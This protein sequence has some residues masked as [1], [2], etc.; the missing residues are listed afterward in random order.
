MSSLRF[1]VDHVLASNPTWKSKRI[2]L[3]TN[4]GAT[5]SQGVLSRVAL[6]HNQFN[7][8][9]L[10][11]PEHGIKAI[12]P[13]GEKVAD[14]IDTPTSLPIVSLYNDT[15]GVSSEAL[16]DID[17]VMMDL[18]DVGVRCYTYLWSG[19]DMLCACAGKNIPF[20]VLDRPNPLG[21]HIENAEGPELET[22]CQSFIG[23]CNIPLTHYC[24]LGELLNYLN[25]IQNI[26]ASL[27]I[28]TCSWKRTENFSSFNLPWKNPSPGIKS[29]N[30]CILYPSL[31]VFESTNLNVARSEDFSFEYIGAEWP[32][33][34][35][36]HSMYSKEVKVTK[37]SFQFNDVVTFGYSLSV[38]APMN[39]PIRFGLELLYYF[40]HS[41]PK[42]FKWCTYATQAN[43]RGE[44]HLDYILGVKDSTQCFDLNKTA[45]QKFIDGALMVDWKNKIK[46]F[47]LYN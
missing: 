2:G 6:L 11:S 4:D 34:W 27:Q 42:N 20:V 18:P 31:C 25:T 9:K 32:F 26:G 15:I 37:K 38:S 43:P 28:I 24:S 46:P 12:A 19:Y 47:L 17:L 30:G 35:Q 40:I 45:F 44:K 10:Y 1:G 5:T 21:G 36:K 41:Y 16:E 3:L 8:K 14:S 22:S 39:N 33:D 7:I 13:D 29:F 23:R